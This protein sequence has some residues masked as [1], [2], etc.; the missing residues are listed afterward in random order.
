VVDALIDLQAAT[1]GPFD[2]TGV[3]AD[4]PGGHASPFRA[5]LFRPALRFSLLALSFFLL[6]TP[7]GFRL[8][9]GFF[10]FDCLGLNVLDKQRALSR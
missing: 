5:A 8:K 6:C 3:A 10:D 1:S 7:F 4:E 9:T 2:G